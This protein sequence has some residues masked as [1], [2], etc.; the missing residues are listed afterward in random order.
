MDEVQKEVTYE[1]TNTY[2]S[3]NALT[4]STK[5][6]W[7]AF[8]GIGYLSRYFI[9]HFKILNPDENYIIAPQAPSK[10]YLNGQYK[11]VGASW[12]TRENTE[13][14]VSNVL[15]Y[16]NEVFMAEA[17][18]PTCK[19]MVFGFSQG[20]SI[21]TRWVARN[22]I[23]CSQIVLYAGGLPGELQPENFEF[24]SETSLVRMVV[25][26]QD[27]FLDKDKLKTE[28][29]RAISLFGSRVV[30]KT[31]SGGHEIKDSLIKEFSG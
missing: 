16:V 2:L 6:V 19:L 29:E 5:N 12:L 24:L 17:V 11:H 8:H 15:R 14:E 7:M 13:A 10:Y 27:K 30:F 25:G 21:A 3:L 20:V 4:T 28:R 9:G 26:D 18:P 1:A 31:F 23:N 22:K